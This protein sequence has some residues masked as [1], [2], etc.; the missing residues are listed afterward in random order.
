MITN[1][2]YNEAVY[3]SKHRSYIN[4]QIIEQGE[5]HYG[6]EQYFSSSRQVSKRKDTNNERADRRKLI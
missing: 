6:E 2:Y 3:S 1:N 4:Q 5:N